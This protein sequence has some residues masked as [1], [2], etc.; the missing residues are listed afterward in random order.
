MT[1]TEAVREYRRTEDAQEE[2]E[3]ALLKIDNAE[4]DLNERRKQLETELKMYDKI[5]LNVFK[6]ELRI[7]R[8]ASLQVRIREIDDQLADQNTKAETLNAVNKSLER[9]QEDLERVFGKHLLY[10][11]Y[12]R[13]YHTI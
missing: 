9:I 10:A 12:D 3:D 5:P 1:I 11:E 2:I 13:M 7:K 6:D 8:K 4:S